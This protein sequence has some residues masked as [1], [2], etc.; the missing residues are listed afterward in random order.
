M[1]DARVLCAAY[2]LLIGLGLVYVIVLGV[3]HR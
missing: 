1:R 2:L 3:L